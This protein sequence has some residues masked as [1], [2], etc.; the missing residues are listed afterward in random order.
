[1]AQTSF[2][3]VML[4]IAATVAL[5]LG[6]VGIYGVIAYTATQRTRETGI[7]LAIGAQIGDVR[8]MFLRQGFE[9]AVLGIAL[10]IAVALGL[11]RL[12]SALLFGVAEVDLIT[13][14]GM[15]LFLGSVALL[16]TYLPA[17]RASRVDPV[18]ALRG[19]V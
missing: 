9:L 12:I 15:S 5:L 13:Y 6:V 2:V 10:G 7:R 11:T 18:T 17:R 8:R 1:M 4:A 14:L 16:A 19:E 3:M